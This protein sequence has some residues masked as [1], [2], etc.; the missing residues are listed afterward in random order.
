MMGLGTEDW[1]ENEDGERM[2][3]GD[4]D[5]DGERDGMWMMGIED[6]DGKGR[7][8]LLVEAVSSHYCPCS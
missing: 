8:G 1:D 7:G 2:G 5:E 4:G 3:M 6:R